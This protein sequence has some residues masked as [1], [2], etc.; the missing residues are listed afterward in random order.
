MLK[1]Y[2][3][4]FV[5][6][7]KNKHYIYITIILLKNIIYYDASIEKLLIYLQSRIITRFIES[8]L[9]LL[10][11]TTQGVSTRQGDIYP[12]PLVEIGTRHL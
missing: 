11:K 1:L 5:P 9:H 7:A 6:C 4:K 10:Q 12:P 3:S 8:F 2:K